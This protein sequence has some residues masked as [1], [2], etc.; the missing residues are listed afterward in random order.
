MEILDDELFESSFENFIVK[1]STDVNRLQIVND[2]SF[3][4]IID[5]DCECNN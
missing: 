5:D 4:T 2:E 1:L 3:V